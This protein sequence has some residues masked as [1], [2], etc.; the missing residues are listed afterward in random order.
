MTTQYI[1]NLIIVAVV[2]PIGLWIA[3]EITKVPRSIRLSVNSKSTSLYEKSLTS[4]E[5]VSRLLFHP[6]E[7]L[8]LKIKDVF[9]DD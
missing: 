8:R 9:K 3:Y 6:L 7:W 4:N 2:I 5:G 1:I